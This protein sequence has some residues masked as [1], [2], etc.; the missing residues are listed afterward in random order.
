MYD[1]GARVCVIRDISRQTLN[2]VEAA[3]RDPI[4]LHHADIAC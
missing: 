1:L 4:D 3:P 2:V